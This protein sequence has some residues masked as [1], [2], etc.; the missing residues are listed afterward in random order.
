MCR[1]TYLGG[2]S[3][4]LEQPLWLARHTEV[5][6]ATTA[7]APARV[8]APAPALALPLL[9]PY[10]CSC[11]CPCS[12][13]APAPAPAPAV[14]LPLPLLLSCPAFS[15]PCP[16]SCPALPFH[17][18]ALALS[19][20]AADP[21]TKLLWSAR[22][23][24]GTTPTFASTPYRLPAVTSV[25]PF[26]YSVTCC[27]LTTLLAKS[28]GQTTGPTSLSGCCKYISGG[29]VLYCLQTQCW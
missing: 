21:A 10:P 19:C 24:Q 25:Q 14:A 1:R 9:L 27:R 18:S 5:T 20:P 16:C 6:A 13:S 23:I 7:P 15:L 29:G 28:S 2:C 4:M 8:L 22:H 26:S 12:C 17:C 11:P 3:T